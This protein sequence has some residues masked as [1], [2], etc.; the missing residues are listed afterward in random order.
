MAEYL[1]EAKSIT[2]VLFCLFLSANLILTVDP[3]RAGLV[4]VGLKMC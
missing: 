2:T 3:A 4:F 1:F